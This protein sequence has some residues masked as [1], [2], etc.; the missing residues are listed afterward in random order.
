MEAGVGV[1]VPNSWIDKTKNGS[2]LE[3]RPS[4]F[5]FVAGATIEKGFHGCLFK[6]VREEWLKKN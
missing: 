6:N 1:L 2:S 4:G 5:F 3:G